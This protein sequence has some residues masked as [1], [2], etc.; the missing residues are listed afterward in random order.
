MTT[1]AEQNHHWII[2]L[3]RWANARG[4]NSISQRMR[5]HIVRQRL[6]N[7]M[8]VAPNNNTRTTTTS[9]TTTMA[10]EGTESSLSGAEDGGSGDSNRLSQIIA[11]FV[12]FSHVSIHRFVSRRDPHHRL[13]FFSVQVHINLIVPSTTEP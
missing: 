3:G 1:A 10:R 7:S 8:Q 4:H 13:F 6:K 12:S 5:W 11:A 9:T 2:K